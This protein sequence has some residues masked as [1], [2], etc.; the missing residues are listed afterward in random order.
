[1]PVRWHSDKKLPSM[2]L[3]EK[4]DFFDGYRVVGDP[5]PRAQ[6][7]NRSSWARFVRPPGRSGRRRL[8]AVERLEVNPAVARRAQ[9]GNTFYEEGRYDWARLTYMEAV[10]AIKYGIFI[11]CDDGP[12]YVFSSVLTTPPHAGHKLGGGSD[13]STTL[14]RTAVRRWML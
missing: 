14:S 8:C 3:E 5:L 10:T 9:M 4:C 11:G 12:E 6:R 13:T 7:L 1:M 2:S